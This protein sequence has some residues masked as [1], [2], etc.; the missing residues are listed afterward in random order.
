VR[1][2]NGE[3]PIVGDRVANVTGRLGTVF[4][5]QLDG[6]RVSQITVKWDDGVIA[7]T[8]RRIDEF[9]LVQRYPVL[10]PSQGRNS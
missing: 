8:Y 2:T 3:T 1:Y 10:E 5:M 6:G 4:D 7:I 9:K